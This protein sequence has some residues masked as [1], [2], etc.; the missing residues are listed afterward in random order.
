MPG[1]SP[2]LACGG[3]WE[4]VALAGSSSCESVFVGL[5]ADPSHPTPQPSAADH[6]PCRPGCARGPAARLD[7]PG[8][9]C[10]PPDA[11]GDSGAAAGTPARA[12]PLPGRS[13]LAGR[14]RVAAPTLRSGL[15]AEVLEKPDAWVERFARNNQVQRL[16]RPTRT[17]PQA[18]PGSRPGRPERR[19]LARSRGQ[20]IGIP[21]LGASSPTMARS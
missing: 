14:A 21:G 2:A 11:R 5:V 13:P 10:C 12:D 6:S 15:A 16:V 7:L 19:T 17:Y 9:G 4:D 8:A 20:T 3:S 18:G 1:T